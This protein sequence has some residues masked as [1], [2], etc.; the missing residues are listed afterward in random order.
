MG[1]RLKEYK[2]LMDG[3]ILYVDEKNMIVFQ[4]IDDDI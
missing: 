2:E 1:I 3:D 4:T